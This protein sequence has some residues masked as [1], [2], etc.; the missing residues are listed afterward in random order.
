M[1]DQ[2]KGLVAAGAA[3]VMRHQRVLWWVLAVNFILGGL[4]AHVAAHTLHEKLS[5]TLAGEPLVS[6]FD[7]GMF[8]ELVNRP[9]VNLL[10][11]HGDSLMSAALFFLF[12]LFVS[13]GILA[14]Y[15]EDRTFTTGEFFAASG[16]FFWRFL[17]LMLLSLVPMAILGF[18]YSGVQSLSD[19][20][21]ERAVADQ[22]SFYVLLAG[23]IVLMMLALCVRL[24]FDIAQVRAVVQNEHGMFRNMWK[25]L[26]IT[27]RNLG[28]LFRAYFFISLFAWVA[29]AIGLW[30]WTMLPATTI[31]LTF[32]LL[33]LIIVTQI[34]ARLWQRASAMSWY[35]R[36][37]VEVPADTVEY[38]TPHPVE[39]T[40]TEPAPA[41]DVRPS[42][43]IPG[44]EE[45]SP[46]NPNSDLPP[47]FE[48]L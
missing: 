15:R 34:A 11:S 36:H 4:G 9:E 8:F 42:E 47:K 14:V 10:S 30:I 19:W 12:M 2:E 23:I 18:L 46:R 26:G 33:E 37:A 38:T 41:I 6:R 3:L 31:P 27:R 45:E 35:Q 39:V 20:V 40:E 44:P 29:L 28:T 21:D 43:E 5:H 24:W 7:L 16:A 13:G 32:L 22:A 17:R 25:A 1:A 48:S